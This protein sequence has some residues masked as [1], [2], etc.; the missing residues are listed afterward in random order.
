[1]HLIALERL[2]AFYS[3]GK[4]ARITQTDETDHAMPYSCSESSCCHN[5]S[6]QVPVQSNICMILEMS[7]G[8]FQDGCQG[9]DIEYLNEMIQANLN[10][11]VAFV[12]FLL[13]LIL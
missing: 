6:H 8:S 13:D 11:H 4:S 3:I 2:N 12:L 5:G 7:F 9:D 10:L 1:M